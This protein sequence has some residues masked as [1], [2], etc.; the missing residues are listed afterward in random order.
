MANDQGLEATA[1]SELLAQI[2]SDR[3]KL[4]EARTSLDRLTR[5]HAAATAEL[6]RRSRELNETER[7]MAARR[8][9]LDRK[10]E[11]LAKRESEVVSQIP[12]LQNIKGRIDQMKF[13]QMQLAAS[14]LDVDNARNELDS[15]RQAFSAREA[16]LEARESALATRLAS[17]QARSEAL[18]AQ[19]RRVKEQESQAQET[20]AAAAELQARLQVATEALAGVQRSIT[21]A[22]IT[23]LT[24]K[25]DNG[26]KFNVD[27]GDFH[28]VLIGNNEYREDGWPDL[29][30]THK[31]VTVVN[32]VLSS[33]YGFKTTV[34]KDADRQT[35][36]KTIAE[37]GAKLGEKD[38]MMIYFAGHGQYF[39]ALS[40]GYWEPVDSI[41]YQTY[42][43]ISVQDVSEQLALTNARKV[44][45]VADSCFSGAFARS[46]YPVLKDD[47]K[48]KAR[49]KYLRQIASKR[50]RNVMTSGGLAPV[51]DALG[52][53]PGHSIFASSFI[54]ALQQNEEIALG[55]DVFAQVQ[56]LVTEAATG[57]NWEQEP[58]YDEII[59]SGHQG[60]DFIFV[61]N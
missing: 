53:L 49:E 52:I 4:N 25:P 21:P 8:D 5:E 48:H 54:Y 40:A 11:R 27:F 44:L 36:L 47:E 55:R 10:E 33:K 32:D 16:D 39:D 18:D 43:S 56:K 59:R 15:Q 50:S 46:P 17:V 30:T 34:L 42:N 28:A 29:N 22:S 6:E 57:S 24:P 26:R 7:Q 60:G 12:E 2:E 13:A 45:V 14:R 51:A 37:L 31:D 9:A 19:E 58:E 38:N 35:I 20:L 41:P 61:P 23:T 1:Q 3:A